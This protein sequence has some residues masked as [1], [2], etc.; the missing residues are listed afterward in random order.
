MPFEV[1]CGNGFEEIAKILLRSGICRESI[2]KGLKW[3]H[4]RN[5]PACV[6]LA[7]EALAKDGAA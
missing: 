1:A 2:V 3:A 6:D 5:H 4:K 7:K